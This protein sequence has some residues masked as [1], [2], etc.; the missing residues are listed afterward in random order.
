MG[1]ESADRSRERG[2]WARGELGGTH[3][4]KQLSAERSS[5]NR[6]REQYTEQRKT[7]F[8][9]YIRQERGTESLCGRASSNSRGAEQAAGA[10]VLEH[11]TNNKEQ[12]YCAYT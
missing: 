10:K 2:T 7:I 8:L 3:R 4:R 1:E 6:R 11:C 5:W 9:C 12:S